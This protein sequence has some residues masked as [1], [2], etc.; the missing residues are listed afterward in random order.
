ML[1]RDRLQRISERETITQQVFVYATYSCATL[2]KG[3]PNTALHELWP[4]PDVSSSRAV[5]TP[6]FSSSR[7]VRT[8]IQHHKNRNF[9]RFKELESPPGSFT[10]L[11]WLKRSL[12]GAKMRTRSVVC[13]SW[14]LSTLDL[15]ITNQQRAVRDRK[16]RDCR[17]WCGELHDCI[18]VFKKRLVVV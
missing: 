14:H 17:C 1:T 10:Q 16:E 12:C 11:R 3:P 7:A 8:Q 2:C 4:H 9:N 18:Y 6:E 13:V 5:R 15:R